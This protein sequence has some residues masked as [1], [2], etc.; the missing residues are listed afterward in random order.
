MYTFDGILNRLTLPLILLFAVGLVSS[1]DDTPIVGG[2]LSPDDVTVNSDSLLISNISVVNSPSF[3]GNRAF[4]TTGRIED[5]VFGDITATALLRP[6]ISRESEADSIGEN[7]VVRLSL[8]V[9]SRYGAETARSDFEIV[10]IARPWRSSSWR[11]DSIPDL[12]KNPD[13]SR[14]VVGQFSISDRDSVT[15]R[16]SEE[17][18][19]RFREIFNRQTSA[20]RDSLYR[21]DMPGLAIVPAEGTQKIFS[22]QVSRARLLVESGDGMRDLSKEISSSAISLEKE[23]PDEAA[24]GSSKPVFNTRGS[25]LELD[26]DFTEEFLGTTNFSRV[27]LV[28]YED[29]VRMKTGIPANFERPRSET[30]LIYYLAPDQLNFAIAVDPRFQ[31]ARRAEDGSYR[32]NLT[33]LANERLRNGG[34]DRRLYA[35]VGGNDGRLIPTLLSGPDDS[36]RQPKLLITSIS[37]EE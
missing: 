14:K 13:M 35:V 9:S 33:N 28:I 7:A 36:R 11:Y 8:N 17:W 30:M 27:E 12:A 26:I 20:L 1:C 29:T 3:S 5:P 32:V 16:L 10:E 37:K 21:A 22:I 4:V 18:T 2:D 19:G 25:M 23:G 24:P 15:V 31:A 34:D 6:S